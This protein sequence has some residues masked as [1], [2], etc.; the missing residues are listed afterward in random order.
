MEWP[1]HQCDGRFYNLKSGRVFKGFVGLTRVHCS[2]TLTHIPPTAT[3]VPV[4][5]PR[6]TGRRAAPRVLMH[7]S[8][9]RNALRVPKE[10]VLT[11]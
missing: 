8:A 6:G 5:L 7:H 3:S 10:I 4:P 2:P 11:A 9:C 1:D